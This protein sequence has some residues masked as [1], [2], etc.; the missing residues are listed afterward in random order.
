MRGG[1]RRHE[2]S[3]WWWLAERRRGSSGSS[4]GGGHLHRQVDDFGAPTHLLRTAVLGL[5]KGCQ[6]ALQDAAYAG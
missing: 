4:H 1:R 3:R 2:R 6:G 5:P